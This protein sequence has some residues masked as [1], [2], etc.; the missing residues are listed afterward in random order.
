MANKEGRRLGDRYDGRRLRKVPAFFGVMPHIMKRRTDSII[1]FDDV[2]DIDEL[3]KYVRRKRKE[4]NLPGFSLFHLLIAAAVRMI[5]LRPWLNRFVM[6]GKLYAR[7]TLTISMTVKRGMNRDAEESTIK[8]EFLPTDTVYDVYHKINDAIEK[9]VMDP[10]VDNDT[11]L[12]A[13][14]LN[15]C[16]S[17]LIRCVVNSVN[18]LD[19]RGLMPKALNRLSPFHTTIFVTDVGSIGITP[20][21]HHI[22]DF[23]TTSMFLAIGK[24][25]TMFV[26][27][28][29]GTIGEKRVVRIRFTLDERICD[30]YYYA[31]SIRSMKRLLKTPQL[32]ENP[33]DEIPKDNW[34]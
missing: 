3:E 9:E 8:P 33:P 10:D 11:D 27:N 4:E 12:V 25:E 13:R 7:N 14:I 22:Y 20:V 15:A 24:K 34:I 16:P 2:I 26:R 32:L 18:F 23:G 5:T 28:A 29:D 1:L 17:W 6:A 21:Y 31:E 30:G 19:H